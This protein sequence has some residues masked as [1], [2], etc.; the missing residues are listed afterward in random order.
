MAKFQGM[1]K[2]LETMFFIL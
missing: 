1:A 2:N